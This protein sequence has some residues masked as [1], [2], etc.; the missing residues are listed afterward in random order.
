L[1]LLLIKTKFGGQNKIFFS[2]RRIQVPSEKLNGT[3]DDYE[4]FNWSISYPEP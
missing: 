2:N 1:V 3:P 4:T